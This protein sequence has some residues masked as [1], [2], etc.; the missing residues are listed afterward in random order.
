M[1]GAGQVRSGFQS[2]TAE[3]SRW[4][5][6]V[7]QGLQSVRFEN[8][9]RTRRDEHY[10]VTLTINAPK[11]IEQLKIREEIETAVRELTGPDEHP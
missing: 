6:K 8:A 3:A 9:F 5:P 10:R 4:V 1:N 2:S 7:I 11:H